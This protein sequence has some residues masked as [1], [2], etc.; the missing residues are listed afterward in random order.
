MWQW[1]VI[2]CNR[3]GRLGMNHKKN[4]ST[5]SVLPSNERINNIVPNYYN[6]IYMV[7]NRFFATGS[8]QYKQILNNNTESDCIKMTEIQYDSIIKVSPSLTSPYI[9]Y[10]FTTNGL[11]RTG[12]LL[13]HQDIDKSN[14]VTTENLKVSNIEEINEITSAEHFAV[15]L[16]KLS[17]TS[18]SKICSNWFRVKLICD[19]IITMIT[20]YYVTN[21]VYFIG[22]PTQFYNQPYAKNKLLNI[23][24]LN[25]KQIIQTAT[26]LSES[27]FL[28][29]EGEIYSFFNKSAYDWFQT[30]YVPKPMDTKITVTCIQAGAQHVLCIDNKN[31]LYAFGNNSYGQ[32]GQSPMEMRTNKLIKFYNSHGQCRQPP[33][34]IG[35][36]KFSHPKLIKSLLGFHV[37]QIKAGYYHSYASTDRN[38]HFLFGSNKRF[39][40]SLEIS[41]KIAMYKPY[42][43]N[44]K[45]AE[46]TGCS[47]ILDVVVG[48]FST[49]IKCV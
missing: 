27:F 29:Q 12:K 34:E 8:N 21:K 11:I 43:I 46:L 30:N 22:G 38:D 41:E 24:S 36:F 9:S 6:T 17:S 37:I 26:C 5:L 19:E 25:D 31:N 32:C 18:I 1:Y 39:E 47:C 2:G 16:A 40:C 48:Y 44:E 20:R 10:W 28:S 23:V 4:I 3:H 42:R 7:N 33:T 45:V 15:A 35:Y 14:V 13:F 49:F